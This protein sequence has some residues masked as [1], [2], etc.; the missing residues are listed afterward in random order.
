MSALIQAVI[1]LALGLACAY[2]L[3]WILLVAW[4]RA[5]L[6]RTARSRWSPLVVA[7]PP[8][9][10]AAVALAV[11]LPANPVAHAVQ[12]PYQRLDHE[13]W[14][15]LSSLTTGD[16]WPLLLA[17]VGVVLAGG[18]TLAWRWLQVARGC[19]AAHRMTQVDG[20]GA[21]PE[22]AELGV[23]N[24]IT[25][26]L[27]RPRVVVDRAWW[28]QLSATDRRLVMAHESA[29]MRRRDPLTLAVLLVLGAFAPRRAF[30][31]V[32]D[33]WEDHAEQCADQAAAAEIGDPLAVAEALL[34]HHRSS[35]LIPGFT[36]AWTG[37]RLEARVLA[38]LEE[39]MDQTVP[40]PDVDAVL[41]GSLAL[42]GAVVLGGAPEL[43]L[44]LELLVNAL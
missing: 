20:R 14:L 27:L 12:G 1:L 42:V 23:P 18:G 26:G 9:V 41:L 19:L 7:L 11:G 32:R 33:C 15:H 17:A 34:A 4:R 8:L 37:G 22:L 38:L 6:R 21:S 28:G 43:H 16:S 5:V 39:P 3:A 29:H 2:A 30:E 10:G 40:G 25:A 36:T 31:G 35:T 13:G 44:V 24:A